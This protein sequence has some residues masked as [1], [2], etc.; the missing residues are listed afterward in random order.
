MWNSFLTVVV[1][2][3]F[4]CSEVKGLYHSDEVRIISENITYFVVAVLNMSS[5][6]FAFYLKLQFDG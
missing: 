2:N 4:E 5:C 1:Q 3:N 6:L